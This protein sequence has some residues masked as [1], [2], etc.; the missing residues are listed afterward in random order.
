MLPEAL[1]LLGITTVLLVLADNSWATVNVVRFPS[2]TPVQVCQPNDTNSSC[3]G[4]GG[5]GTPGGSKS[6]IQFYDTNGTLQIFGGNSGLVYT[7]TGSTAGNVGIGT[8]SPTAL[9]QVGG[10]GN[11]GVNSTNP[12]QTLDVSGTTRST[13]FIAG[14]GGITLG[15]VNNTTWPSGTSQWTGTSPI[16]YNGNV[17]INSTTP[18]QAL[19]V[20]GSV[21]ATNFIGAG[22][23]LTGTASSLSIGG[24]SATTTALASS[25]TNCTS[26]QAPTGINASGTAQNC[27]AFYLNSNPSSYIALTALNGVSPITYNSSNGNIGINT[28]GTWNGNTVTSTTVSTINGQ[29]TN[30]APITLSGS[31]TSG[32]PYN[33]GINTTGTWNGNSATVQTINGLIT[34]GSNVTISGS[35]TS[36]SPYSIASS[37]G[38]GSNQWVYSSSGNIGL[39]TTSAVGVGTTYVGGTGE[40]EFTVMGGNVG[41]GT[42]V[43]AVPLHVVASE[44]DAILQDSTLTNR[45]FMGF[46]NETANAGSYSLFGR[47]GS[48]GG[49]LFNGTSPYATVF[50]SFNGTAPFQFAVN[51]TNGDNI[52]MTIVSSGNVGIGTTNP[53][54]KLIAWGGNVGIGTNVPG[55]ALD[56]TGT[57]RTTNFTMTGQTPVSGY[58]LTASDSAGDTAWSPAGGIAGWTV[59][60][61]NVYT[62]TGSNNVGI[63]TSTPQGG[64]VVT[65]GNVGIGTWA[66]APGTVLDVEGT[67]STS[68]FAGNVGIGTL[69]PDIPYAKFNVKKTA[70][71]Q[72]QLESGAYLNWTLPA[73]STLVSMGL[74]S[75]IVDTGSAASSGGHLIGIFG[76][77]VDNSAS[78]VPFYGTEGR[79]DCSAPADGC[80]G[81]FGIANWADSNSGNS[82]VRANNTVGLTTQAGQFN[83]DG[84]TPRTSGTGNTYGIVV[85]TNYGGLY[86][87]GVVVDSQ[88]SG[89]ADFGEV[90]YPSSSGALWLNPNSE[91]GTMGDH[92]FW[93]SNG[94]TDLYENSQNILQTDGGL[95]IANNVGIGTATATTD[96]LMVKGSMQLLGNLAGGTTGNIGIGTATTGAGA[97]CDSK[98]NTAGQRCAFGF[99]KTSVSMVPCS[100]SMVGDCVCLP[101]T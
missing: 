17:G 71:P 11:V 56:V 81:L 42:W 28:T 87:I 86:N 99:N 61:T 25:P 3:G 5:S 31:G 58:V 10:T 21:Q 64:L 41:I 72:Q 8:A 27:T 12:G 74:S 75:Y 76:R 63:G 34:N 23:G 53:L 14:T 67:L 59:S 2:G 43:P 19:D 20:A 15:G 4:S 98:C 95:L 40:G 24:N 89:I 46:Y 62:T 29:I 101:V 6:D 1:V 38:G 36:A 16:Y 94:T 69:T 37:G 91:G 30:T 54:G 57:I 88:T 52:V 93:G 92:I 51:K 78:Q 66:P 84:V 35:G 50:G 26:N 65:N 73:S 45:T 100:T 44:A 82:T 55:Q 47:E 83:Y 22:T 48:A 32:S 90:I 49:S 96:A 68:F 39:S 33:V 70:S 18:G 7:G 77:A 60:G 80:T 85:G 13:M 97:T 9:F 79:S